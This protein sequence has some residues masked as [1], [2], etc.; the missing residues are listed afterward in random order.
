MPRLTTGSVFKA[1]DGYGIR[2][3]ED[4]KRPVTGYGRFDHRQSLQAE[5]RR[6]CQQHDAGRAARSAIEVLRSSDCE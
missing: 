2:W 4:G 1:A 6:L 3:P 5:D